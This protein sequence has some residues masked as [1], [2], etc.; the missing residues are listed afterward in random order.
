MPSQLEINNALSALIYGQPGSGKTT[1]GRML[2]QL[3][4][5]VFVDSDHEIEKEAG[6]SIPEYFS[7]YGE[8]PNA[9]LIAKSIC[10]AREIKPIE[11]TFDLVEVIKYKA[12]Q[13]DGTMLC[14]EILSKQDFEINASKIKSGVCE[15]LYSL[16]NPRKRHQK[17][18][19][20]PE[21]FF[22]E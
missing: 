12:V 22:N 3:T 8:E 13:E 19:K 7:K 18:S 14:D 1:I 6:M 11:T 4:G 5:K 9:Y 10:K 15:I 21:D 2:S 16:Y 17:E 20:I